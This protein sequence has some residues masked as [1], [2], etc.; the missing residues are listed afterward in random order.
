[1]RGFG[2]ILNK[3]EITR[4]IEYS[5]L[6]P[7]W[8]KLYKLNIHSNSSVM[9]VVGV[10][11]INNLFFR[12]SMILSNTQSVIEYEKLIIDVDYNV[13]PTNQQQ[14]LATIKQYYNITNKINYD[15]FTINRFG[16]VNP[17]KIWLIDAYYDYDIETHHLY[18]D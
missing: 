13:V 2:T 11:N 8:K 6:I 16:Y 12:P 3:K 15:L 9:N 7:K 17:V 5:N 14:V 1:M 10:L 18:L 4:L